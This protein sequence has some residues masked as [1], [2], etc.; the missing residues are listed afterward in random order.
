MVHRSALPSTSDNLR[1]SIYRKLRC[2]SVSVPVSVLLQYLCV[3][4]CSEM[5]MSVSMPLS[6]SV[7]VQYL[8]VR[9]CSEMLMSV[10]VSVSVLAQYLRVYQCSEVSVREYFSANVSVTIKV[11]K[12]L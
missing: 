11:L 10:S 4:L 5:L 7:L 2:V 9:Q 8:C 6:V 1:P 12:Y 3:R